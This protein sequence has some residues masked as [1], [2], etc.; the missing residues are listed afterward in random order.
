MMPQNGYSPKY[1]DATARH[2]TLKHHQPQH[3]SIYMQNNI[4]HHTYQ[5]FSEVSLTTASVHRAMT[6]QRTGDAEQG[7]H[8]DT[9]TRGDRYLLAIVPAAVVQ[10]DCFQRDLDAEK[11]EISAVPAVN[12]MLYTHSEAA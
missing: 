7:I 1:Q 5:M 6:A 11:L 3:K 12:S 10:F 4:S 9:V 8:G 2:S